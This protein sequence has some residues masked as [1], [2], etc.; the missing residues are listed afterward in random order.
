[1]K[2][3]IMPGELISNTPKRINGAYIENGKTYASIITMLDKESGYALALEGAWMPR[4]D[5]TVIGTISAVKNHVYEIDLLHF[6]RGLIIESKFDKLSL[7]VGDVVSA[8]V[9]DVE[10]RKTVI[11]EETRT[12][13]GGVLIGIKPSKI[14]RVVG[15][16]NTM[17]KMLVQ[18]TGSHMVVGYNGI[19]WIN[20][21]D[22]NA[23]IRA[24]KI[25][26]DEAH[27][28]G[29]TE[30]LHQMLEKTVDKSAISVEPKRTQNRESNNRTDWA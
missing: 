10:D 28:S 7:D 24:I 4:I 11:L 21:G 3:I 29:L 9:R 18:T 12:L 26:E 1:M 5:D 2:S 13:N 22:Y 23:A 20:G 30:R 17:I 15:K 14:P 16:E 19:I 8:K 6:G 25:I 27:T